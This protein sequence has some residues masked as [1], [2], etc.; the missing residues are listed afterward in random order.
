MPSIFDGDQFQITFIWFDGDYRGEL[1]GPDSK[2]SN[3][4]EG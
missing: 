3:K 1:A 2:L 4:R